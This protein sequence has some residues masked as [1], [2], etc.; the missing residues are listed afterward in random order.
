MFPFRQHRGKVIGLAFSPNGDF[1]Y[2]VGSLGSIAL[3]DSSDNSYELIRLLGNT[4]ARG[5]KFGPDAVAVSP[6]GQ[7][8]AF[9]GPTEYTISVASARSL[10]EVR[11]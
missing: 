4:V 2:S 8:I 3:Y 9:I 1:M 6:G 10:D 11:T 7:Y 5:E